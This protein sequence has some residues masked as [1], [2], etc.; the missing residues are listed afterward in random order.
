MVTIQFRGEPVELSAEEEKRARQIVQKGLGRIALGQENQ[1]V[2]QRAKQ[3]QAEGLRRARGLKGVAKLGAETAQASREQRFAEGRQ[4]QADITVIQQAQ[5]RQARV[6]ASDRPT[7]QMQLSVQQKAAQGLLPQQQQAQT[8]SAFNFQKVSTPQGEAI[9]STRTGKIISEQP[10]QKVSVGQKITEFVFGE[11]GKQFIGIGQSPIGIT[12]GKPAIT[13]QQIKEKV[14]EGGIPTVF[15]LGRKPFSPEPFITFGK[16]DLAPKVAAEIIPTT[17]GDVAITGG[18]GATFGVLPK[19]VRIGVGT[20]IA[21]LETPTVLDPGKPIEKRISAGLFGGLAATG[22]TFEAVPFIRG[23]SA[24]TLGRIS[25]EFKP[26]KT[27]VV[28]ETFTRRGAEVFLSERATGFEIKP[29]FIPFVSPGPKSLL[30]KKAGTF[31]S[32]EKLPGGIKAIRDVPKIGDVAIIPKGDPLKEGLTTDVTLPSTSQLKRGGFGVKDSEKAQFLG[33]P[34]KV[35]TS[36]ISFFKKGKDILLDRDFFV[37]PQET[38]LKIATTRESRLGLERPLESPKLKDV[39][40]GFG[41]PG[42]AQTGT[43]LEATISR[44]GLGESFKIGKGSELEATKNLATITDV[45]RVAVTTLRGQRVDVFT[46]KTSEG[47]I[48][49]VSVPSQTTEG[50]VKISGESLFGSAEGSKDLTKS[51]KVKTQTIPS[52]S[53]TTPT[54]KSS[55]VT[56]PTIS[57]SSTGISPPTRISDSP[58]ITS[59]S[60]PKS[61]KSTPSRKPT[62]SPPLSLPKSLPFFPPSEPPPRQPSFEFRTKK[63]PRRQSFTVSVR[64]FGKFKPIGTFGTLKQA[65]AVGRARVA[66]T[67]AATFKIE[68]SKLPGTPKGFYTKQTPTGKLFI[69]RSKFRLSRRGEKKEIQAAKKRKRG[70]RKSKWH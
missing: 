50:T 27:A 56:I 10:T 12:T 35:A 5:Q 60:L 3:L 15:G 4:T 16:G 14:A 25:G 59:L 37:T 66:G 2:V 23:A 39:E 21:A 41:L 67:L 9:V 29:G 68:G 47:K 30:F 26:I 54:L 8:L 42:K 28:E 38:T 62:I 61:I 46:F 70:G 24:Q 43:E 22:A 44:S 6:I 11:S 53:L 7:Q 33:G 55:T 1:L 36:Q 51:L 34:Q 52:V 20:G 64:R 40:V 49:T 32:F 17:P 48:G 65:T 63:L 69:E 19:V 45:K 13:A 18:L 58:K 57:I 31:V